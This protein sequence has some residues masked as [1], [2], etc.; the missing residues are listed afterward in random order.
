MRLR[1]KNSNKFCAWQAGTSLPQIPV[2]KM[3]DWLSTL[4]GDAVKSGPMPR[5]L[6][7]RIAFV[8]ERPKSWDAF[9]LG[10]VKENESLAL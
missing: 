9:E 3:A 4:N 5:K 2:K 7:S 1:D 10:A 8:H 6:T